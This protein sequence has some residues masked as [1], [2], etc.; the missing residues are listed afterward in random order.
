MAIVAAQLSWLFMFATQRAHLRAECM[1]R[2]EDQY[3]S[4]AKRQV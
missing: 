3:A 4:W 2:K 1:V